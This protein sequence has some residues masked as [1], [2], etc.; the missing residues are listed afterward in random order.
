MKIEGRIKQNLHY[1]ELMSNGLTSEMIKKL[2]NEKFHS[3]INAQLSLL[4]T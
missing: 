3:L 4:A 2:L 1:H